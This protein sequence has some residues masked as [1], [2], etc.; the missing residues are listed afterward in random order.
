MKGIL[1]TIVDRIIE[2][3]GALF[4]EYDAASFPVLMREPPIDPFADGKDFAVI[5][6]IKKASPSKGLLRDA[7]DPASLAREYE[8]GGASAVSVV[9]E[10]NFFLGGKDSLRRVREAVSLPILRKDFIVHERQVRE[11]YNLGA[12]MVLLIAACLDRDTLSRLVEK[13]G[14][15][16]NDGSRRNPR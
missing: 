4:R 12:D 2:D 7:L 11:S 6:E 13:N 1:K 14:S 9:T 10:K 15:I 5:A 3:E 16:G 8:R